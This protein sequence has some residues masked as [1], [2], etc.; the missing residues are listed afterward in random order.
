MCGDLRVST[1][2]ES[3]YK[4]F[5]ASPAETEGRLI[6][7]LGNG[8]WNIPQLRE[9]LETILPR[10]SS[11]NDFEVSHEFE[12][13]GQRTMLLN[14]RMLLQGEGKN[15]LILLGIQDITETLQFQAGLRGRADELARFNRAA[16]GREMRM[17]DLKKEINALCQ[18]LGEPAPYPLDFE[19]KGENADG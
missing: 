9:F 19:Q 12:N 10:N 5:K 8:Q 13:I 2:N 3:F 6:Y 11:F 7:E 15:K 4:I 1:A 17:I 14:G 18:R 16:V